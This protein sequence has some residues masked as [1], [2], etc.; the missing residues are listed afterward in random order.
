M[1]PLFQKCYFLFT[2]FPEVKGYQLTPL[3]V[4]RNHDTVGDGFHLLCTIGVGDHLLGIVLTGVNVVVCDAI[5]DERAMMIE[6]LSNEELIVE[7][8]VCC[9]HCYLCFTDYDT[10]IRKPQEL[11]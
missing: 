11:Q 3:D 1:S 10:N 9:S 2:I 7:C 5:E 6:S 8:V 4:V